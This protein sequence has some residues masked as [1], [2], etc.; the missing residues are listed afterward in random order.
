MKMAGEPCG[1]STKKSIAPFLAPLP[2]LLISHVYNIHRLV[3]PKQVSDHV[4]KSTKIC[5]GNFGGIGSWKHVVDWSQLFNKTHNVLRRSYGQLLNPHP[6]DPL[7][8]QVKACH[9]R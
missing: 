2:C 8:P 5:N 6:Y 9:N 7:Y 1:V 3:S 4:N